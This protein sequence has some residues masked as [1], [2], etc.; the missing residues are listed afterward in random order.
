[1]KIKIDKN[2]PVHQVSDPRISARFPLKELGVGH[3]FFTPCVDA[4][5]RKIGS[6]QMGTILGGYM[7]SHV[8]TNCGKKKFSRRID[9]GKKGYRVWRI[10]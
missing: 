3:S 1:M 9:I 4:Q 10:K 6:I 7:S 5:G 8:Y 2:I